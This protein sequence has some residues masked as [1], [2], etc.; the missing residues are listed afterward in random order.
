MTNLKSTEPSDELYRSFLTK[1]NLDPLMVEG[2]KK[3]IGYSNED[4]LK[5]TPRQH[6]SWKAQY[7]LNE[8][9]LVAD[10]VEVHN[11]GAKAKVGDRY[12]I[13]SATS[14]VPEECTVRFLC[15]Y[16][17]SPITQMGNILYERLAEGLDP[18]DFGANEYAYCTDTG[19]ECGGYGKILMKLSFQ[20]VSEFKSAKNISY[21]NKVTKK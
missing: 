13:Q 15:T 18:R 5:T 1:N 6:K 8:W 2:I 7:K 12:V 17:I 14:L 4:I 19:V 10:I 3:F 16:A 20:H 21:W 11:C 9:F